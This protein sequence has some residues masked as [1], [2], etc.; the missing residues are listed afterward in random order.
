MPASGMA[1]PPSGIWGAM[2]WPPAQLWP[3]GQALLQAPQCWALSMVFT[4]RPPQSVKPMGQLQAPFVQRVPPVHTTPHEPQLLL[5]E[6]V[7]VHWPPHEVKPLQLCTQLPPMHD[8][9]EGQALPHIPQLSGS[10]LTLVHA[11][12]QLVRPPPQPHWPLL[13]V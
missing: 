11:P 9:P 10:V 13:H 6:L 5:S 2:H 1:A 4:H 7:L 8:C 3:A 12:E